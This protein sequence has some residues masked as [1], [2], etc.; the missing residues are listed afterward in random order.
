M[1]LSNSSREAV[2]SRAPLFPG[3]DGQVLSKESF[4]SLVR[5]TLQACDVE[6][7]T[8]YE[9]QTLQ[10]FTG[11]IARVSGAQ[12]LRN[13]GVPLQMLQ[14]LGRWSSLTIL[15]YL[16]SAP[17]QVLPDVAAAALQEGQ[18][19]RPRATPWLMVADP[20]SSHEAVVLEDSDDPSAPGGLP[21]GRGRKRKARAA[22]STSTD[23][24]AS[25]VGD[26]G[27][28]LGFGAP[29]REAEDSK[30]VEALTMEVATMRAA[31]EDLKGRDSFIVQGRSRKHHR[32]GVP[33]KANMPA[34][35]ATVCGWRY[36]L[37]KFYRASWVGSSDVRC[38]RCFP[39]CFDRTEGSD[40][41]T[42]DSDDSRSA[43]G[44]SSSSSSDSS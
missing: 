36:G 13:L 2:S 18:P 19:Q 17:L 15:R 11:H 24:P 39:E 5:S 4:V 40:A 21:P 10:R 14:V 28:S 29:L 23:Q 30:A 38:Q 16:Q 9:G 20:A 6:T 31:L 32:I 41:A 27:E 33:E 37:S 35:W 22:A 7:T 44:E 34:T 25:A 12:W 3:E 1:R 26:A 43:S 8:E 42:D